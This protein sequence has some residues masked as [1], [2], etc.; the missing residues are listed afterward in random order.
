MRPTG[1][2]WTGDSPPCSSS[3]PIDVAAAAAPATM[4]P[5]T[6]RRR[7]GVR[8]RAGV[9]DRPARRSAR[10]LPRRGAGQARAES[11]ADLGAR[12]GVDLDAA[13]LLTGRAAQLG[14]TR[15]GRVSAGGAT[16]LLPTRD[17]WCAITL[18]R[19]DDVDAVPALLERDDR[20]RRHLAG[21]RTLGRNQRQPTRSSAAPACSACPRRCSARRLPVRPSCGE[22]VRRHRPG[23]RPTCWSPTCPRCGRARCAGRFW[24][25]RAP[26]WSRSRARPGPTAPAAAQ[27]RSST[28]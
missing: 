22:S 18:S 26:R 24:R 2:C 23:R 15:G 3:G 4:G 17:G 9:P 8:Q 19:P 20:R 25:R 27:R 16:R 12:I 7:T 10:L 13:A 6:R 11:T 21:R 5:W 1:R 14:L 28:G